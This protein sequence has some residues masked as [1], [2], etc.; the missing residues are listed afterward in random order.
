[1]SKQTLIDELVKIN[2]RILT[3]INAYPMTE[4]NL[5][6]RAELVN[7]HIL[8]D[9][10]I[11][12]YN[13]DWISVDDRDNPPPY[14]QEV[15]VYLYNKENPEKSYVKT[16]RFV[17]AYPHKSESHGFNW[18]IMNLNYEV[19]LWQPLPQEPKEILGE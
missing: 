6:V 15:I 16:E 7:V 4:H 19:L 5:A 17:N 13:N 8:I 10:L 12:H 11:N 18:G 2:K 14:Q 1:M 3:A 9:D